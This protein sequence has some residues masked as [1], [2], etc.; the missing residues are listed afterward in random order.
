MRKSVLATTKMSLCNR[1]KEKELKCLQNYEEVFQETTLKYSPNL[2][3]YFEFVN[4][5]CLFFATFFFLNKKVL[6]FFL[7]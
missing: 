2:V 1:V 4:V 6:S 5:G 3:M 7:P